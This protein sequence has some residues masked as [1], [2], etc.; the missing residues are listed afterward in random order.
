MPYRREYTPCPSEDK[1]GASAFPS[2]A[3]W[4]PRSPAGTSR[5]AT[6]LPAHRRFLRAAEDRGIESLRGA[7]RDNRVLLR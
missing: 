7:W 1:T 3:S 6:R 2:V 5:F 4:G